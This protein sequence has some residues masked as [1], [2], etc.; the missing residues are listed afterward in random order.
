VW[1]EGARLFLVFKDVGLDV[2]LGVW[3]F[4]FFFGEGGGGL[5]VSGCWWDEFFPAAFQGI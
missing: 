3:G 5:F 2:P 1:E 4:F